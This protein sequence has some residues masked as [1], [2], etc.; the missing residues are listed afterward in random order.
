[1][2][3]SVPIF[4]GAAAS[5]APSRRACCPLHRGHTSPLRWHTVA[6]LSP[7]KVV[8]CA[9]STLRGSA[10][11]RPEAT[12]SRGEARTPPCSPVCCAR[13]RYCLLSSRRT[14]SPVRWPYARPRR[15]RAVEPDRRR[16]DSTVWQGS[17]REWRP[18]DTRSAVRATGRRCRLDG[19]TAGTR[20]VPPC[21]RCRC[22]PR[23]C[24]G[25]LRPPR[26]I[27]YAIGKDDACRVPPGRSP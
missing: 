10:R 3:V 12:R 14:T 22:G 25:G 13:L 23:S 1:M 26:A 17:R 11:R 2:L 24:L 27:L 7:P 19:S 16:R 15:P 8:D 5:L 6:V 4:L 20:S 21:R 9:D 18:A